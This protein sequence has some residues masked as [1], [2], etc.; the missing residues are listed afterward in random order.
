MPPDGWLALLRP[1]LA[2]LGVRVMDSIP[3]GVEVCRR[4]GSGRVL[5]F[6]INHNGTEQTLDLPGRY[7][8]LLGQRTVEGQLALG[9]YG[10]AILDGA[11]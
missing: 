2:Q 9:P 10:V 5:T 7:E 1:V 6:V 4:E 8:D 3:V 11:L